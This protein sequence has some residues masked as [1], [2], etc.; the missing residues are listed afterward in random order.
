MVLECYL[1]L[2][3]LVVLNEMFLNL[4]VMAFI[5][6]FMLPILNFVAEWVR[7]R[8]FPMLKRL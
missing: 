1:L 7:E 5:R 3:P 6:F 2:L 8:A 4:F